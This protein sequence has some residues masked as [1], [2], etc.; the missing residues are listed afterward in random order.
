[1]RLEIR[2]RGEREICATWGA[3]VTRICDGVRT[4]ID[5]LIRVNAL[6]EELLQQ[7]PAIGMLLV[8]THGTPLPTP[9]TQRFA[10][11]AMRELD[12]KLVLSVAALGLGFWADAL[13][14]S[15]ATIARI[16]A[17]S[18]IA[19]EHSVEAAAQRLAAELIGIDPD[20]LLGVYRQLWAELRR[21]A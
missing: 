10:I 11:T 17:G 16:V 9:A 12:D 5:D 13:R 7:R 3:V 19:I 8:F 21:P 15:I 6:F 4:E 20:A 1:M 2:Y 14:A 18:T